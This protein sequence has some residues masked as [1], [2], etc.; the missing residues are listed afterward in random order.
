MKCNER[1]STIEPT[2]NLKIT[3]RLYM[4][5]SKIN[6]ITNAINMMTHRSIEGSDFNSFG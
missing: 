4:L 5:K 6:I 3:G 2:E 1:K